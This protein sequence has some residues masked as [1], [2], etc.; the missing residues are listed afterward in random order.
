MQGICMISHVQTGQLSH[1]YF[2]EDLTCETQQTLS[3]TLAARDVFVVSGSAL[4]VIW[5]K[6]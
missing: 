3:V 6:S 4:S 2:K 1:A 5:C